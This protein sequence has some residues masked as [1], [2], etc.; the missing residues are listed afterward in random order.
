M[1]VE[2]R[3]YSAPPKRGGDIVPRRQERVFNQG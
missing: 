2:Q 3:E 1:K